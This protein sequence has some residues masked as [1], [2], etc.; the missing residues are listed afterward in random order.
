MSIIRWS[1]GIIC[2]VVS[3]GSTLIMA[4]EVKFCSSAS[5]RSQGSHSHQG[6]A[7]GVN[8][9]GVIHASGTCRVSYQA[10][11]PTN[12]LGTRLQKPQSVCVCVCVCVGGGGGRVLATP[13]TT[14]ILNLL[15]ADSFQR[16]I[17]HVVLLANANY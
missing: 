10:V 3:T 2:T 16:V 6:E 17:L 7:L 14:R 1:P 4:G 9:R 8:D 5:S 12:G 15:R 11:S 13:H